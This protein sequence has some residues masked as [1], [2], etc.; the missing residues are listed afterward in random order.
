MKVCKSLCK[1]KQKMLRAFARWKLCQLQ[2]KYFNFIWFETSLSPGFSHIWYSVSLMRKGAKKIKLESQHGML[3]TPKLSDKE[4]DMWDLRAGYLPVYICLNFSCLFH[5]ACSHNSHS[6]FEE[7]I[8]PDMRLFQY[9]SS[10][11][12]TYQ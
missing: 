10:R 12:V 1:R 4:Y 5:Q 3:K 6:C 2:Q 8:N 7:R 9:G 11:Y